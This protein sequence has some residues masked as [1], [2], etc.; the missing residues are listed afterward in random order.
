MKLKE[1]FPDNPNEVFDFNVLN[2]I[3]EPHSSS[4]VKKTEKQP[5]ALS[6]KK[7]S[8]I[9]RARK[10]RTI[11]KMKAKSTNAEQTDTP[12]H[13]HIGGHVSTFLLR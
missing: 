10:I 6:P 2:K 5:K 1:L 13:S 7:S 8:N 3:N 4:V 9:E 11:A 12:H